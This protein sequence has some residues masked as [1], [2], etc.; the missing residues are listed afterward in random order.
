MKPVKIL[1]NVQ[2][3]RYQKQMQHVVDFV[4]INDGIFEPKSIHLGT[5]LPRKRHSKSEGSHRRIQMTIA[6]YL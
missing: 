4:P 3:W 2:N 5:A 6:G 1:K